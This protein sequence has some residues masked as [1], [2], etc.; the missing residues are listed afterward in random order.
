MRVD[1]K[2]DI[3]I[4]HDIMPG[5]SE[6]IVRRRRAA[7]YGAVGLSARHDRAWSVGDI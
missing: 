7:W 2:Q 1:V 3:R 5:N 6:E 4:H